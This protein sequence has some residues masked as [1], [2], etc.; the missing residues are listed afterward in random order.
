MLKIIQNLPKIFRGNEKIFRPLSGVAK[1]TPVPENEQKSP[2]KP[3]YKRI[4]QSKEVI[5]LSIVSKMKLYTGAIAISAFP[6]GYTVQAIM[7]EIEGAPLLAFLM[8]KLRN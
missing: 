2:Q 5:Q 6:M 3:T 8:G 7:P 4:Y 1:V